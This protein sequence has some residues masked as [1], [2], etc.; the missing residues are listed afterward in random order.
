MGIGDLVKE[1]AAKVVSS[2][3]AGGGGSSVQKSGGNSGSAS[4][5]VFDSSYYNDSNNTTAAQAIQNLINNSSLFGSSVGAYQSRM[6]CGVEQL[7]NNEEWRIAM[8]TDG[9]GEQESV[10]LAD[11]IASSFDSELDLYIQ[12][13]V[14]DVIEK[15]GASS[16]VGYLTEPALKEL[17]SFGIRVDSIGDLESITNRTYSFTLVEVPDDIAAQG[18][19]A[20]HDWLYNTEEG[21]NAK[22]IEDANGK[23]GS[24][25]F[26]DC[27]IPDGCAQ[28]AE[29][30]LSSILDQM[31]YDCISKADFIGKEDDYF[32][33]METIEQDRLNGWSS[34][35]FKFGDETMS[36]L[37]GNRKDIRQSVQDL[38]GGR[39]PA[40]GIYGTGGASSPSELEGLT[41]EEKAEFEEKEK[42]M[43]AIKDYISQRTDYYTKQAE[44]NGESVDAEKISRKVD[45]DVTAK[46]GSQALSDLKN[47]EIA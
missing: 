34:G 7:V 28:G 4:G 38:W 1:Q 18:A 15:Y 24:Y 10:K 45:Q 36:D 2:G 35:M 3:N 22:A 17:A 47:V 32:K 11:A 43:D 29:V 20:I 40:P 39:G 30:N 12:E 16:L 27:L 23:K 25:I 14:N 26:S 41:A 8:D 46:F 9:D 42:E 5:S 33:L 37:Y 13:K 6:V 21:K 44:E 31:G 19:D